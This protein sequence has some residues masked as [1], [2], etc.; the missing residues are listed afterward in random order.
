M[1]HLRISNCKQRHY[2]VPK[3]LDVDETPRTGAGRGDRAVRAAR[4]PF[5]PLRRRQ[6][7]GERQDQPGHLV[8]PWGDALASALSSELSGTEQE[9]R[10][11]GSG[12]G[13]EGH[14]RRGPGRDCTVDVPGRPTPIG[15]KAGCIGYYSTVPHGPPWYHS[16]H[17]SSPA[18]PGIELKH[19]AVRFEV[20]PSSRP[21]PDATHL[22]TDCSW[23]NR[24]VGGWP[25]PRAGS[26]EQ[27][28]GER[29][30]LIVKVCPL[31]VALKCP[32]T[33]HRRLDTAGRGCAGPRGTAMSP[34]LH[35]CHGRRAAIPRPI[36]VGSIG[37]MRMRPRCSLDPPQ[38]MHEHML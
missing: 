7:P 18:S 19:L 31:K 25:R 27:E 14:P 5:R 24:M 8:G 11:S 37:C 17:Y 32:V 4:R 12:S 15:W 1:R 34:L 10:G 35:G 13:S 20:G 38:C 28:A 36:S 6:L 23:S 26:R 9:R 3:P 33:A 22:A 29:F 21:A 2:P 16:C 30:G